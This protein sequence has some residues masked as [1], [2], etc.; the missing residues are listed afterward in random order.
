MRRSTM[1]VWLSGAMY[2]M[3]WFLPVVDGGT[4]LATG[5]VPGWEALRAA[6]APIWPYQDIQV[7]SGLE[8]LLRVGSGL[9]NLLFISALI[10][11]LVRPSPGAR[12]ARWGLALAALLNTQWFAMS[13]REDLRAGYYLWVGSFALL[14]VGAHLP[15]PMRPPDVREAGG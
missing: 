12:I 3:A 1:I 7:P 4:T 14:A 8:A 13:G 15:S 5:G 10:G 11:L 6:L 2:V 9:S